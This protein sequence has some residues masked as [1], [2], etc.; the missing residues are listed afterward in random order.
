[1][2]R[3]RE[4]HNWNILETTYMIYIERLII[5]FENCLQ[6]LV[7]ISKIVSQCWP[8]K[9][10]GGH[11]DSDVHNYNILGTTHMKIK[12]ERIIVSEE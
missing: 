6:N 8:N 4:V 11:M 5:S 7:Q 1:M 2:D 10:T 3:G 12:I 9:W